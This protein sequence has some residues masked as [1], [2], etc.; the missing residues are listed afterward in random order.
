MQRIMEQ[1]K[2]EIVTYDVGDGFFIDVETSIAE[3]E[4]YSVWLSHTSF[5]V[6]HLCFGALKK[7]ISNRMELEELII[8]YLDSSIKHYK[9]EVMAEFLNEDE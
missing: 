8:A 6:K 2:R 5:G 1:I 3:S 9:R 7:D 4:E